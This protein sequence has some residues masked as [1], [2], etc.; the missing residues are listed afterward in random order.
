MSGVAIHTFIH[1]TQDAE[2]KDSRV[3]IATQG[4]L[5]GHQLYT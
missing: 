4:Y 1:R 3:D 2:I 5:L